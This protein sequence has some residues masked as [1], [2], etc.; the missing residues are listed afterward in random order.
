MNFKKLNKIIPFAV[1]FQ[2]QYIYTPSGSF[3]DSNFLVRVTSSVFNPF[4][5]T[6]AQ[7]SNPAGSKTQNEYAMKMTAA[8]LS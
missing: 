4:L 5:L 1:S 8:A 6:H 3:R 2:S 7:I